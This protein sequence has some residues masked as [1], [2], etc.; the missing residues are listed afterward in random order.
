MVAL[1]VVDFGSLSK[2]AFADSL[3]C[4]WVKISVYL[5]LLTSVNTVSFPNLIY[6]LI[7][8]SSVHTPSF[9]VT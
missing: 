2:A 1:L 5:V 3:N 4:F 8:P 7:N 9:S 6:I